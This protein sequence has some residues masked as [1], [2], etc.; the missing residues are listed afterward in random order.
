MNTIKS[1]VTE[2]QKEGKVKIYTREK[3]DENELYMMRKFIYEPRKFGKSYRVDGSSNKYTLLDISA[4]KAFSNFMEMEYINKGENI[5][6]MWGETKWD[7]VK[8][9]QYKPHVIN[10][11][12]WTGKI[13]GNYTS[14]FIH[15][16]ERLSY[17][18]KRDQYYYYY[19]NERLY[20][21]TEYLL[22]N[23]N[24]DKYNI[25]LK[26][27]NNV[28]NLNTFILDLSGIGHPALMM[29]RDKHLTICDMMRS[30]LPMSYIYTKKRMS[31]IKNILNKA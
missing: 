1:G 3:L 12:I 4:V 30:L 26:H 11:I 6:L 23:R 22:Q 31:T 20:L 8:T 28:I 17:D 24:I 9:I 10:K 15:V 21:K 18:N 5:S 29:I 13:N 19:N 16:G 27:K 25:I 7:V 14:V 2:A